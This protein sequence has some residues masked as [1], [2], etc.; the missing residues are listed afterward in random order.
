MSLI[1]T[2]PSSNHSV[3]VRLVVSDSKM[4]TYLHETLGG[5]CELSKKIK[6]DLIGQ[7]GTAIKNDSSGKELFVFSPAFVLQKDQSCCGVFSLKATR[8]FHKVPAL[9]DWLKQLS[10][11]KQKIQRCAGIALNERQIPLN[12]MPARLLKNSQGRVKN[13]S[14]QK[15]DEIVSG[16]GKQERSLSLVQYQEKYRR[17]MESLT[18]SLSQS[19]P[20]FSVT[21]KKYKA[22]LTYEALI[23]KKSD[24][25]PQN[26]ETD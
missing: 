14:K 15:L 2:D 21:C 11:G 10:Q 18:D 17:S 13:L 19:R 12:E 25:G 26:M 3:M 7:L 6:L 1:Y 20:N 23:E 4:I 24:L 8:A 5:N 22:L 9:D 16:L